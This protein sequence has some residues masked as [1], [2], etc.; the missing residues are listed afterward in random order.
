MLMKVYTNIEDDIFK[1]KQRSYVHVYSFD[2]YVHFYNQEI[3]KEFKFKLSMLKDIDYFEK[4]SNFNYTQ[5]EYYIEWKNYVNIILL[6]KIKEFHNYLI[7]LTNKKFNLLNYKNEL[8]DIRD[9]RSFFEF[10]NYLLNVNEEI[11]IE[12]CNY[13]LIT[14]YDE[15]SNDVTV[16][17]EF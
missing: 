10:K 12:F 14:E 3:I 7:N 2:Y 15:V 8:Y 16:R 13:N 4:N 5:P 1:V 9:I 17:L 11:I 6:K